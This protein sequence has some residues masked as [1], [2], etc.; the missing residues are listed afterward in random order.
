M[1]I[2]NSETIDFLAIEHGRAKIV[3]AISDHWDWS[4]PLEH[5]YAL[6][7]KMNSYALFI[8]SGQ[9]WESASEQSGSAVAPGSI[10]IEIKVFLSCEPPQVFFEFMGR[11]QEV[12]AA[13]GVP[14]VHELRP[15]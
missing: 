9:V 1:S 10:P 6:Q 11:A 5:V 15:G 3:L 7:E 14:V 2:D 12:F 13:V 4:K 8:E